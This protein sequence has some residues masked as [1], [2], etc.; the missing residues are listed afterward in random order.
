MQN[1]LRTLFT[2]KSPS[3]NSML[4]GIR[5]SRLSLKDTSENGLR[6]Q[7][8]IV[9]MHDLLRKS[10]IPPSWVECHVQIA[11]SK[12]RGQGLYVRLVLKHWDERLMKYAFAFQKTLLTDIVQFEPK[13][14]GWLHGISWQLE[15]ATSCPY[16]DLPE[17]TSRQV[18]PH[19]VRLRQPCPYRPQRQQHQWHGPR[20][21][22]PFIKTRLRQCQKMTRKKIW[23]DY[24]PFVTRNWHTTQTSSRYRPAMKTLSLRLSFDFLLYF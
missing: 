4:P 5:D 19:P 12:S 9:T 18:R 13:A 22:L 20:R 17:S 2:R 16:P 14:A 3:A 8:V 1:F 11:H 7:I 10:G 6:Q 24:L 21:F 15:V 23:S